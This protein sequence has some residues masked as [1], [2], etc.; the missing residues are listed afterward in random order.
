MKDEIPK[1][2]STCKTSQWSNFQ[3]K[4]ILLQ[5]EQLLHLEP[6]TVQDHIEQSKFF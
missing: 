1:Y 2:F 3:D 5:L 6:S 4:E